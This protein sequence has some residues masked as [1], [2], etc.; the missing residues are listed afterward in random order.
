MSRTITKKNIEKYRDYDGSGTIN[1]IWDAGPLDVAVLCSFSRT[2]KLVFHFNDLATLAHVHVF[3]RLTKLDVSNCD[4]TPFGKLRSLTGLVSLPQLQ[5]FKC[6]RNELTT[7][8]GIENCPNLTKLDLS[9]NKLTSLAGL[10][11]LQQLSEFDCDHNELSSLDG[12][13]KCLPLTKLSCSYNQ[14]VSLGGASGCPRLQRLCSDYN[15]LTSLAELRDCP[16]LQ[17]LLCDN[18]WL[19]SVIGIINCPSLQVLSCD[20]NQLTS[21]ELENYPGLVY[22]Y[23]DHNELISLAGIEQA[24]LL[25]IL[26]CRYNRLRHLEQIVYLRQLRYL[27]Y[28]GNPINIP[29]IQLQRCF[30]RIERLNHNSSIYADTQNVHDPHIQKTVC[31]SIQSLLR[32]PKPE[33]SIDAVLE[34]GMSERAIRLLIEYCEDQS[35]HS[36][37]LLTYAELLGYVWARVCRSEHKDELIKILAEQVC[38]AECKCF[39]GRFNRTV[40]VLVGFYPDIMITISDNSRISA[41]ILASR[42]MT[43]QYDPQAHYETARSQLL[44]AG[45]TESHIKP[46]LDA[47]IE[48]E[49]DE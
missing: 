13:A 40:S 25:E 49:D 22:L 37:H 6:I 24:T 29:S 12:V 44:D 43:G 1:L 11:H 10:E 4:L 20:H 42:A 23:C 3:S 48:D 14:L 26:N 18:N 35:V 30:D 17:R 34:S 45:Y 21:L 46:W 19:T 41:I 33:F 7:L 15:Q 9:H 16:K 27:R 47:I 2:V 31:D 5:E 38:D 28:E 36:H 8:A 39:T 32:D